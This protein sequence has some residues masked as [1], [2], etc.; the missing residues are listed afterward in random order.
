MTRKNAKILITLRIIAENPNIL[1]GSI[2]K[3]SNTKTPFK[4]YKAFLTDLAEQGLLETSLTPTNLIA[5]SVTAEGKLWI[6]DNLPN[7]K[8]LQDY[9]GNCDTCGEYSTRL[10]TF[11]KKSECPNCLN[12]D[13]YREQPFKNRSSIDLCRDF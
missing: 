11:Q 2:K 13:F 3:L 9:T 1:S 12:H 10:S 4:K 7:Q 8:S 6:D 5:F